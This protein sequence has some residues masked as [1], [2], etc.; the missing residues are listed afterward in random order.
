[1]TAEDKEIVRRL[2]EVYSWK[3]GEAD[4]DMEAWNAHAANAEQ[5]LPWRED[6]A[7]ATW[8]QDVAWRAARVRT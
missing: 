4:A 8:L 5:E 7:R 1:M 3:P 2:V 6:P